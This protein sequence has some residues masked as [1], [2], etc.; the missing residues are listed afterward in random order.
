[1]QPSSA[2]EAVAALRDL[3]TAGQALHPAGSGSRGGWGGADPPDSMPFHTAGLDRIVSHDVGDFTAVLQ[4]GVPLAAAQAEFAHSG[5]WLAIDPA[6]HPD[7]GAGTIGGLVATADSGPARHAYGGVRDLVIGATVALSDGTL[8]HS[9]GKVIKNVAGYDL[10]KLLTGSYGTLGLIVEVAVRLHPIPPSTA[11]V[12]VADED[13][14]RLVST[15]LGLARTA[16]DASCLDLS[17]SAGAGQV[18]LRYAGHAARE[19]AADLA[20]Q[21]SGAKVVDDDDPLWTHQRSGQRGALVAKVSGRPTDLSIVV[22]VAERHRAQLT[23]RVALGL[24]WLSLPAGT[25]LA[26]VR[27]DLAPRA[28]MVLDGGAGVA[29]PWPAVAAPALD[30]MGR[31]KQ[32]F[33]PAG[34][35]RPGCFVGGL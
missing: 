24:S 33:D 32:R 5:Q 17:W 12:V 18:L 1:V 25:D 34:V 3:A 19:R 15:A 22:E 29:D 2:A 20:T 9:G 8:A 6:P 26:A 31:V 11:T 13:A 16:S 7:R 10:G 28:V 35:F 30:L 23:T 21:V 27:A 4:A 14:A